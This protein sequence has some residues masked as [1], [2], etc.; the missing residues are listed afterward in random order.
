[1]AQVIVTSRHGIAQNTI[2]G[3]RFFNSTVGRIS[4]EISEELAEQFAGPHPDQF[5]RH[6]GEPVEPPTTAKRSSAAAG[7][8]APAPAP[9][10]ATPV[11]ETPTF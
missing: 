9:V 2:G 7:A 11:G 1:M 5:K 10:R 6:F 3:V 8:K 4:E